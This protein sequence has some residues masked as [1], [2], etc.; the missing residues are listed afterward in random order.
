MD[1]ENH[2]HELEGEADEKDSIAIA[3]AD[4]LERDSD[5]CIHYHDGRNRVPFVFDLDREEK[6][7]NLKN[8]DKVT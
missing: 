2:D 1:I 5:H 6:N 3:T 8:M 4:E 7:L